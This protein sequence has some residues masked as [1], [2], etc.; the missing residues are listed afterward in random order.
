MEYWLPYQQQ[1]LW[2][3]LI[4]DLGG[5]PAVPTAPFH[6]HRSWDQ[7]EQVP[8]PGYPTWSWRRRK[9]VP[10]CIAWPQHC[11][12]RWNQSFRDRPP[13]GST[14][15]NPRSYVP[16]HRRSSCHRVDGIYPWCHRRYGHFYGVACPE[17]VPAPSWHRGYVSVPAS[18]RPGYPAGHGQ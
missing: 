14:G 12:H 16:G 4:K 9:D 3:R 13:V 18:S 8:C 2:C 17:Q 11:L 10:L 5:L 7:K 1:Y 15:N 6:F